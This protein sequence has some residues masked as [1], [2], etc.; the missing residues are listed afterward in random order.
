[1]AGV[2][3]IF[4]HKRHKWSFI[5]S[6]S[7]TPPLGGRRLWRNYGDAE[8]IDLF[9]LEQQP[10]RIHDKPEAATLPQARNLNFSRLTK[11]KHDPNFSQTDFQL[12]GPHEITCKPAYHRPPAGDFT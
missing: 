8:M 11:S 4:L 1:M 6:Y 9:A 2:N 5:T 12:G 10:K 7:S 3:A